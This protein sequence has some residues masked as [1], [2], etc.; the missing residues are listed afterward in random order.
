MN[1]IVFFFVL[2]LA[3]SCSNDNGD[4]NNILPN[5]P[6]NETIFLN[7][8]QFINLQVVGGWSYSQGGIKGI[9]IYHSSINNYVAFERA[10]PHL[11]PS[12]CSQM[13]VEN[14]IKMVC[15][16]DDSEFNL[17]NGAP[18]TDGVK[19]PARQYRVSLIGPNTLSITNF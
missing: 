6:V 14:S 17:L 4:P 15:P 13:S 16:C 19:F 9:I 5:V 12:S 8:P 1:K 2:F 18:L 3:F 7:N 10:C 11:T